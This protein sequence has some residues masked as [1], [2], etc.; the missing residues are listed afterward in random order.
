VHLQEVLLGPKLVREGGTHAR[1]ASQMGACRLQG[2]TPSMHASR[3]MHTKLQTTNP[4]IIT[5]T[6]VKISPANLK[7][8]GIGS[9]SCRRLQQSPWRF[10][11]R[12][13]RP[14][15]AASRRRCTSKAVRTSK[16]CTTVQRI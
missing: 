10:S 14:V 1:T 16:R 11:S 6:R 5:S 12:R 4:N 13:Q 2:L 9:G 3:S 8:G 15:T 7:Q